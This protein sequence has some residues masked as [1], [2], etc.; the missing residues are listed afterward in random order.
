MNID[1][2]LLV[3]LNNN[4]GM[5]SLV[6]SIRVHYYN[7]MEISIQTIWM[8]RISQIKDKLIFIFNLVISKFNSVVLNLNLKST[9]WNMSNLKDKEWLKEKSLAS[10]TCFNGHSQ[11]AN[12]V[13]WTKTI[14]KTSQTWLLKASK[15]TWVLMQNISITVEINNF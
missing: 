1:Y 5:L 10:H 9:I 6:S 4:G 12:P 13:I 11:K 8:T 14:C 15:P 3:I 2:H 7:L